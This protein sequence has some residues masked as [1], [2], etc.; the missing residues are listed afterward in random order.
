MNKQLLAL[1][2]LCMQIQDQPHKQ[3]LL[4]VSEYFLGFKYGA[5]ANGSSIENIR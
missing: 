5:W 3:R 1:H 2:A 4:T